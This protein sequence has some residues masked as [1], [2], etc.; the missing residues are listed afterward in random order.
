MTEIKLC[1]EVIAAIE[2]IVRS[3]HNAKV[4]T[5]KDGVTV[6]EEKVTKVHIDKARPQRQTSL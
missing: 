6:Y 5:G 2:Q 3:G 1:P 4:T